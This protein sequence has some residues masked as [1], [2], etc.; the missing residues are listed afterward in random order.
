MKNESHG[1]KRHGNLKLLPVEHLP[2]NSCFNNSDVKNYQYKPAGVTR[3]NKHMS[4]IGSTCSSFKDLMNNN[5]I[6]KHEA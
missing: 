2:Q 6:G 4:S 5:E 1:V 3:V